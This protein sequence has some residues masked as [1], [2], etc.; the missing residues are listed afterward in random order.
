MR[1]TY[2]KGGCK[3]LF[4]LIGVIAIEGVIVVGDKAVLRRA[5]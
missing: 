2:S 1:I 4:V 5:G 3:M